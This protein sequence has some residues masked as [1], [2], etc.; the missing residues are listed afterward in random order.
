MVDATGRELPWVDR[1]GNVLET[2][3]DRCRPASGQKFFLKGGG[4]TWF[5]KHEYIGPDIA[6][7]EELIKKGYKLPFYADLSSLP[8]MERKAIW[9]LMIGH[10]SKTKIP[11]KKMYE[12]AGFDPSKDL[13]RS[14]GDSWWSA[15]FEPSE[16]QFFGLPGGLVNN[17]ELRTNLEGLY[18][19]GD[20]LFASD[21]HGHAAATGYYAGRH[22]VRYTMSAP[23]PVVEENQVKKERELAYA[24]AKLDK[25]VEWKD[26]NVSITK[27]MQ[28]YCGEEKSDVLLNRGLKALH[29][30]RKEDG[31]NVFARNPHEL[32][33]ALE[34]LNI[35]TNAEIVIHSSLARKASCKQ[36][37]FMRSDYTEID[38][39]QWHKFVVVSKNSNGV[40]VSELPIDYYSSLNENYEKYNQDYIKENSV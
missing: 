28:E 7:T 31:T 37:H 32:M 40:R 6:P 9:G 19:S 12:D 29:D 23:E 33:R 30:L 15:K 39:P 10:E 8:K 26:L 35:M 18:A 38:P 13:L 16:R 22:A 11:V 36:L 5:Q 17:W 21:C 27:I 3:A 4:E 2:V 24:P 20:T 25:G 1:D 14:Y 34:V